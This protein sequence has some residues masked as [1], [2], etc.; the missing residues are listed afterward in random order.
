MKRTTNKLPWLLCFAL[1]ILAII[2]GRLNQAGKLTSLQMTLH[3]IIT[4]GRLLA[5]A[6]GN[7]EPTNT[8][9]SLN[10][11]DLAELQNQLLSNE[12][13][14][15]QLLIENARLKQQ[16]LQAKHLPA[17]SHQ[18]ERSLLK[19][20]VV[21]A[22]IVSQKGT[23]EVL[24]AAL[25]DAGRSAGLRP[26][27]L[28]I[29]NSSPL[30]D[31]GLDMQIAPGQPVVT[32]SVIVGRIQKTAAWVSSL[33]LVTDED[34]SAAVEIFRDSQFTSE[35]PTIGLLRGSGDRHCRIDSVPYTA[36]VSV[37]DDVF[38]ADLN[39]LNG[40]RLYF[41]KVTKAQFSAGGEWQ[42]VVTPAIN[43]RQIHNVS[44]VRSELNSNR[45]GSSANLETPNHTDPNS[46]A[47]R[48]RN[49]PNTFLAT[50]RS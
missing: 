37:G 23:P 31:Q 14:R 12:L 16:L 40:P 32:G 8:A 27:Q 50:P 29:S 3:N 11:T 19:F 21:P 48:Q 45:I 17:R 39:G 4:P 49:S 28:V 13:Q 18:L 41:G 10:Q 15:R 44:V 38:S 20:D 42:I 2:V 33:Q 26:S 9:P 6:I 22:Q 35:F 24:K 47:S 30:L 5:A 25:I 43:G 36:A 7:P 1:C 46:A 34:F